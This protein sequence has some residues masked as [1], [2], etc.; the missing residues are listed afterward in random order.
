MSAATGTT[1]RLVVVGVGHRD[2][3]DDA[4]GPAIIDE[5]RRRVGDGVSAVVCEGD[6]AVL[7]LFWEPDDDVVIVDANVSSGPS[8]ELHEIDPDDV[9]S[10]IGLSTHGL[11]VAD[12]IQ[13]AR[14]LRCYP[15]SLRIFGV[16]GREFGYGPMSAQMSRRVEPLTDELMDLL[17]LSPDASETHPGDTPH[18]VAG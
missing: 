11:N 2:R 16:S 14:R 5:L 6:L 15:A 9:V 10:S 17:G 13:L 18:R 8:G 12:A 7:P 1:R 4:I 3:G